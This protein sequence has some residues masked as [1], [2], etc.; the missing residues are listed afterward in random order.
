MDMHL[1]DRV[2]MVTGGASGIGR[3]CVDLLASEGANV[4]IVDRNPDGATAAEQLRKDGQQVSFAQADHR[5]GLG[6]CHGSQRPRE[7]PACQVLRPTTA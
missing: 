3:A 1:R 5:Q 4:L 2:V 6:P 7:L